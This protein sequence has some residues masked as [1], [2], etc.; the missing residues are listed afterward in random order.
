MP[1]P[2]VDEI[3]TFFMYVPL[4]EAGFAF[5]RASVM[6]LRFAPSCSLLKDSFP[7]GACT[8]PGARPS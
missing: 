2:I 5:T 6:L 8:M 4:A 7:N 1:G 3:V